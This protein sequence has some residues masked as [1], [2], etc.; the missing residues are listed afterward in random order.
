METAQL[1]IEGAPE[2]ELIERWRYEQLRS[3]GYEQATAIELAGRPEVDLHLAV[4]LLRDG[5]PPALA[6]RILR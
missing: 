5:C 1:E 4:D 2:E 6:L 3:V